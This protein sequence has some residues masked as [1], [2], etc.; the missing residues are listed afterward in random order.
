MVSPE[1]LKPNE[2]LR[3]A[4]KAVDMNLLHQREAGE[5]AED[6]TSE[7]G[8]VAFED[9]AAVGGLWATPRNWDGESASMCSTR[10]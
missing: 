4:P 3:D 6:M 9:A 7:P 10:F 5:H 2:F 8:G 1:A